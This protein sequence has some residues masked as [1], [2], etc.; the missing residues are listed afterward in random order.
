VQILLR[1]TVNVERVMKIL[2]CFADEGVESECLSAYGDVIRVGHDARDTNDSQPIKAKVEHL[3]FRE[4]VTFDLGLF[5]RPCGFVSPMSDTGTGGR[6]SW[7]NLIPTAREIA[8]RYCR[9]H[10]IE[11]KPSEHINATVVLNGHMFGLNI[12][13]ERAFETNFPVNQPPN[14]SKLAETSPFFYSEKPKKWWQAKKGCSGNY[15]KAHI[16][17]NAIP[18]A[19]INHIMAD[20]AEVMQSPES[21]YTDYNKIM[22]IRRAQEAN[23]QLGDWE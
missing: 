6:D 3:P 8:T 11:N 9:Y 19:Y 22:D 17:K 18:R 4:N 16:A 21:D 20:L 10:I 14:Q 15:S 2:H 23:H 7:D 12:K 13:Y 5:H 1:R